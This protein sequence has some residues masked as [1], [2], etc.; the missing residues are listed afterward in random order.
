MDKSA[1]IDFD[2]SCQI[3]SP[4]YFKSYFA[5]SMAVDCMNQSKSLDNAF[6]EHPVTS[7]ISINRSSNR[8]SVWNQ[9]SVNNSKYNGVADMTGVCSGSKILQK[10]C[11]YARVVSLKKNSRQRSHSID[12]ARLWKSK[13]VDIYFILFLLYFL[14]SIFS[15]GECL[16]RVSIS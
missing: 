2:L 14:I 11:D 1:K 4:H 3:S 12:A 6:L 7:E 9:L 13:Q 16:K 10:D 15:K 5:R 8:E